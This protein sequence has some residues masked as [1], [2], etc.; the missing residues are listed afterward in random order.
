MTPPTPVQERVLVL[1]RAIP[2]ESTK[3]GTVVCCAGLTDSG[4]FRRLYPVPFHPVRRGGGSPFRKKQWITARLMPPDARDKRSESRKI[5][6]KSI[7][8]GDKVDD[9]EV[10]KR[11]QPVLS[12]SIGEIVGKGATLGFLRPQLIDYEFRIVKDPTMPEQLKFD[13]DGQL[14]AGTTVR[15]P[16]ESKYKFQCRD[17]ASCECAYSP[18]DMIIRDW[19]VNELFRNVSE[20]TP[21]DYIE[22]KMRNRMFGSMLARDLYFMMGTHS[23]YKN[24]LLVSLLYLRKP[25]AK[26]SPSLLNDFL[27]GP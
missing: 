18:H 21:P 6:M 5:D 14:A 27:D 19:E 26:G 12:N 15:L 8:A 24:W 22:G 9:E 20:N 10:R 1:C 16:Q 2:E 25:D 17:P 7:V 11:I 13:P 4:E 3:Y 23:I